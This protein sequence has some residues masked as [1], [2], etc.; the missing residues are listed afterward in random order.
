MNNYRDYS[1]TE[2]L[3]ALY[4]LT[5]AYLNSES[6]KELFGVPVDLNYELCNGNVYLWWFPD[7]MQD[8]SNILTFVIE[9][10]RV[11]IYNGA[12]DIEVNTSG[13]LDFI[14]QLGW[15]DIKKYLK[16]EK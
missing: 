2:P 11:L 4:G 3:D 1:A 16:S 13:V 10:T 8:V 15:K 7:F 9:N 6:T 14:A 12:D 5:N